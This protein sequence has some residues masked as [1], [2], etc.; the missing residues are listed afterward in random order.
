M[1]RNKPITKR[2]FI[3]DANADLHLQQNYNKYNMDE[4]NIE[5]EDGSKLRKD[6]CISMTEQEWNTLTNHIKHKIGNVSKSKW[7]KYACWKLMNEEINEN[8]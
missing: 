5:K 8:L 2:N 3:E 6:I 1:I 4:F 7:I